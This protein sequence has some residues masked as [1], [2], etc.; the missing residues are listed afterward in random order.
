VQGLQFQGEY[1]PQALQ[2]FGVLSVGASLGL[3]NTS[4]AGALTDSLGGLLSYGYQARYQAYFIRNQW[5]VPTIGFGGEWVRY[6]LK[7]GATGTVSTTGIFYGAMLLL[8]AFDS[9]T[10]S[11]LYANTGVSR[12]Y[13]L[14]EARSRSGSDANLT[15]SGQSYF[16]GLRFEF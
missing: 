3:Y 6:N 16:F 2:S 15:L 7:S 1:Q 4:P 13:L 11:E 12:V 8:S 10:A 14:A 5:V 9:A